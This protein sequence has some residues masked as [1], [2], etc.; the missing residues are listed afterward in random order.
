MGAVGRGLWDRGCGTGAVGRLGQPF[1]HLG[2][3]ATLGVSAY[4]LRGFR[5]RIFEVVASPKEPVNCLKNSNVKPLTIFMGKLTFLLFFSS[6]SSS[7]GISSFIW[8]HEGL[9]PTSD[10][11]VTALCKQVIE[12]L[13]LEF[14]CGLN[15]LRELHETNT[16]CSSAF[17]PHPSLLPLLPPLHTHTFMTLLTNS[18]FQTEVKNP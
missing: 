5:E 1:P 12:K 3:G 9:L 6:F 18:I 11:W 2:P 7:S 10:S 8:F 15:L 14:R 4:S 17:S 16:I 13:P